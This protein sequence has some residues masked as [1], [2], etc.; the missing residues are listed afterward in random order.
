M[1]LAQTGLANPGFVLAKYSVYELQTHDEYH[2][3]RPWQDAAWSALR[4]AVVDSVLESSRCRLGKVAHSKTN[5]RFQEI[6][7]YSRYTCSSHC[8][9]LRIRDY[10]ALSSS[11]A[12]PACHSDLT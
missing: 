5:A 12:T 1:Q 9:R 7:A 6:P 3:I 2:I 10:Q 8:A 4:G 11:F